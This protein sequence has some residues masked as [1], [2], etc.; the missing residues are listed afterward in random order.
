VPT[1]SWFPV[2]LQVDTVQ[3]NLY[4]WSS[5]YLT[6][7]PVVQIMCGFDLPS[8]ENVIQN[9][10]NIKILT[11]IH[12]QRGL[13]REYRCWQRK[14]SDNT[15][16]CLLENNFYLPWDLLV[17]HRLGSTL[18]TTTVFFRVTP[19]IPGKITQLGRAQCDDNCELYE[20]SDFPLPQNIQRVFGVHPASQ[21]MVTGT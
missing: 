4:S 3:P 18:F 15:V 6:M 12:L 21:S 20:A 8:W 7:L 10:K 14:C 17:Q 9:Y 19:F 2:I 1:N 16:Q 13:F 5:V 11:G